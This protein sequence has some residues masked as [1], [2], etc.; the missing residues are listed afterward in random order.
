MK[1]EENSEEA[2]LLDM[3]DTLNVDEEAD[4]STS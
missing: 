1:Q 4:M 2:D 3:S